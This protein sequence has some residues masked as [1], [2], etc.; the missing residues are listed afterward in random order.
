M[1]YVCKRKCFHAK[2]GGVWK[3]YRVGDYVDFASPKDGPLDKD[4]K[5]L[6][7]EPLEAPKAEVKEDKPDK[8][9]AFKPVDKATIIKPA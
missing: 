5:L 2:P 9:G 3:L 8:V 7:F 6:H 1:R 4:G